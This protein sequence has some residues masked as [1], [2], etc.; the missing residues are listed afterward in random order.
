M[1]EMRIEAVLFASSFRW[2]GASNINHALRADRS[3]TLCGRVGWITEEGPQP[4]DTI[5]CIRCTQALKRQSS[6]VR[7]HSECGH[8]AGTSNHCVYQKEKST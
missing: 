3:K 8:I 5:C 7:D 4:V 2:E 6:D 1:S